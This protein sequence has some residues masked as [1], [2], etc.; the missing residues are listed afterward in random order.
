M[1][2]GGSC[3]VPGYDVLAKLG[4]GG[5]GIVYKA[6]QV[7]L[8]RPVALK[9]LLA[10]AHA[11]PEE[12]ARFRR[13]AEAIARLNHP[14]IVR[15]Y[16]VGEHAGLLYFS[17]EFC[18]GGSLA[19]HLAG[20]PLAPP[21]AARLT[22]TLARAVQTAHE[23]GVIHRDLKPANILL[24]LS[25]ERSASAET[26]LA[27]RSR[28]NEGVL[29][30]SDF[31]LAK[32]LDS[33]TELTG[34]GAV[35]GTPS[36]M[37]PEQAGGRT[38]ELGPAADVYALGAILYECLTGRP[39]FLAASPLETLCQVLAD[40]PAP[41]SR[42]RRQIPAAL[43]AIC[44][45]CLE[46]EPHR[47]Y[48][49]AAALAQAL[50]RA[51]KSNFQGHQ[52]GPRPLR[53]Q[54]RDS[55]AR[56]RW[57]LR[58]I[59]L[60]LL[61]FAVPALFIGYAVPERTPRAEFAAGAVA[62]LSPDGRQLLIADGAEASLYD[63]YDGRQLAAYQAA[64]EFTAAA[65]SADGRTLALGEAGGE[66]ELWDLQTHHSRNRFRAHQGP[67]RTLVFSSDGYLFAG[68]GKP[69]ERTERIGTVRSRMDQENE[70]FTA[71]HSAEQK[72]HVEAVSC[73]EA[74]GVRPALNITGLLSP[75]GRSLVEKTPQGLR[76]WDSITGRLRATLPV[77]PEEG[78][79]LSFSPDGRILATA[80]P[81]GDLR[82][83]DSVTG[84]LRVRVP[85]TASII[86]FSPG[87]LLLVGNRLW[88]TETGEELGKVP[89]GYAHAFSP[90]GRALL[91]LSRRDEPDRRLA[92]NYLHLAD[93][94]SGQERA[95]VELGRLPMT[96]GDIAPF[97]LLAISA[98]GRTLLTGH[99]PGE[100]GRGGRLRVWDWEP[101]WEGKPFVAALRPLG[102]IA[103]IPGL[104]VAAFAIVR[105]KPRNSALALAFQSDGRAVAV[106]C[107]D[108]SLRLVNLESE[109]QVRPDRSGPGEQKG[110]RSRR[111]R[112]AIRAL[113]FQKRQAGELLAFLDDAG[114]VRLWDPASRQPPL[115]LFTMDRVMAAAFSTDGH[116]LACTTRLGRRKHQVWLCDVAEQQREPALLG[117][118][119]EALVKRK[120][121]EFVWWLEESHKKRK[122]LAAG[123]A[124]GFFCLG[125]LANF[126]IGLL[127]S[128]TVAWDHGWIFAAILFGAPPVLF[129]LAWWLG[130]ARLIRRAVCRFNREFP[131]NT[132]EHPFALKL[133]SERD[134]PLSSSK[135]VKAILEASLTPVDPETLAPS[136]GLCLDSESGVFTAITFA[137]CGTVFAA[138]TETG[139]RLYRLQDG[140]RLTEQI[141]IGAPVHTGAT[142]AFT[143]D[144]QFL[145]VRQADGSLQ[146]WDATT[147]E[148][149]HPAIWPRNGLT[150]VYAPDGASALTLNYD[151]TASLWDL[152]TGWE[153]AVLEIDEPPQVTISAPG[154]QS[155]G[156]ADV[157]HEGVQ[158]AAFSPAGDRL[159]LADGQGDVAWCDVAAVRR[160][161]RRR[162][163]RKT[164]NSG[165]G[166]HS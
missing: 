160:P 156:L 93:V 73:W 115:P 32:K 140:R 29:K 20:K 127:T 149:V 84:N 153:K 95:Q 161:A 45:K 121:A 58:R 28:L 41:P 108:G 15:I 9:A 130:G 72:G 61:L 131:T 37:A 148:L 68:R 134:S 11:G 164:L 57:L 79:V 53:R 46:K 25:R 48:A 122:G 123:S 86:L 70:I 8:D 16:E 63:T 159:A 36:Y 162:R 51:L 157:L 163:K 19:Q 69:G 60:T 106:G 62:C 141:L 33:T 129:G 64:I 3:E 99:S 7:G 155:R 26:A 43:E 40:A 105:R 102:W 135:R 30:I 145:V 101:Y 152:A 85:D 38:G 81:K 75:D 17:M 111:F 55:R 44:L 1:L 88:N 76:L 124:V 2:E 21:E 98:N 91:F 31:G 118:E 116:R 5:M 82:L 112:P 146:V 132:A 78:L 138:L 14:N 109:E 52:P 27:E 113:A 120:V 166:L 107:Q 97:G 165:N 150:L 13:E 77:Q 83:W 87:H 35:L 24:S 6:R 142:P 92:I 74:G 137:P 100:E 10:G 158:C 42:L 119:A 139:L 114:R 144:G 49:S 147:C 110:Q 90:D 128:Y 104:G 80:P 54:A 143:A 56:R 39:P 59:A 34:P 67:I 12:R 50:E 18:E 126:V 136:R 66:V 125:F 4:Q 65:I 23:A 117:Q 151:G 154:P 71:E 89:Y 133:L 96:T 47:R 103:L 22:A 94:A